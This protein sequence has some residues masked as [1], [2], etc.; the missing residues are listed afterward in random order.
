M[1]AHGCTKLV[2]SSSA[3]VYGPENPVPYVETMP[4]HLAT[5]PEGWT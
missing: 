3:T 2:F 5:N 1:T 4:A